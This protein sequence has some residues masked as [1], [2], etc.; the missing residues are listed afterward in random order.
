MKERETLPDKVLELVD[1]IELIDLPPEELIERLRE[2][3]VYIQEQI[4]RAIQNFFSKGNPT[5]LREIAM[6]VAADRV[7]AQMT[8]NMCTHAIPG[9]WPTQERVMVC[10]N[11]APVADVRDIAAGDGKFR[12][13]TLAI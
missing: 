6:R 8:A 2:G 11:G 7:E 1:E 5:A 10:F 9:P 4:A 13:A 12:F 3:E